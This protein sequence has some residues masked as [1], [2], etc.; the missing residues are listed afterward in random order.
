M[1]RKGPLGAVPKTVAWWPQAVKSLAS[2]CLLG[3]LVNDYAQ[4]PLLQAEDLFCCYVRTVCGQQVSNRSGEA[5]YARVCTACSGA[6]GEDFARALCAMD[7]EDLRK[8]GF[9]QGKQKALRS[10][11]CGYLDGA[12]AAEVLAPLTD[13][14][15]ANKL[16]ALPGVGPWSATMILLFGLGRPDVFAGGDF[17]VRKALQQ[18]FSLPTPPSSRE[19]MDQGSQWHPWASAATWLLWRSISPNPVQY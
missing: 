15:A 12:L 10:L 13:E 19:A 8:L 18:L 11:S 7:E 5:L 9:H 1:V 16:T 17:G 4:C 6:V 14:Q 3:P 2:D